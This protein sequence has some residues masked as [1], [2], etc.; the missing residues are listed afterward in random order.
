MAFV[1]FLLAGCMGPS[2]DSALREDSIEAYEAF[3]TANPGSAYDAPAKKRLEE[4]YFDQASKAGTPEAWDAYLNRFPEG[5]AHYPQALKAASGAAWKKAQ[6]DGTPEALQVYLDKYGKGE[7]IL[8]EKARGL[9][10]W[11]KYGKLE[12]SEPRIAKVNLAEDPKGELNGWGVEVDVTNAGDATLP[13]VRLSVDWKGANG[14]DY[15]TRDY[16]LTAERWSLPATEEQQTPIK[17]GEKRVWSWSEDFAKVPAD[18]T[19]SA[20]VYVSGFRAKE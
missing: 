7:K 12:L 1:A 8:A 14:E 17:P 9:M 13:Y 5:G 10:D 3:L 16:P 18:A 15:G 2:Y 11:K 4:L 6:A 20:T 19:P